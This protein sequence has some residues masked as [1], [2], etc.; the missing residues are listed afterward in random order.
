[1]TEAAAQHDDEWVRRPRN[2]AEGTN[3]TADQY[4]A[5][6]ARSIDDSDAFWLE[7]ADRLDWIEKPTKAGKPSTSVSE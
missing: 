2:A 5:M 1:M 3:C 7:Q 6:Y 4:A